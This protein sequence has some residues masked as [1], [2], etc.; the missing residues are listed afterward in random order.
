MNKCIN[1]FYEELDPDRWIPYDRYLRRLIRRLIR[2]KPRPGGQMRV[3]LNL[4]A[5]L[6]KLG[7]SYRINDYRYIQK[8]PEEIACI[9]GKHHV[10]DKIQWRNPILFGAAVFSHPYEDLNL[11][12]RLPVRK[13][14]VPGEWMRQMCQPYYE[15]RVVAWPVGIDTET[16]ISTSTVS[17]DVDILLYDKVLWEHN[18]YEENIVNRVHSYLNQQDLAIEV[19]RYGFY[20]EQDFKNLLKRCKAMVFLCEHETQGIAYQQALSSGVP[21]LAWDRGGYWQD[22]A[23]FPHRVKFAPVS[24][25]PYW[26]DRCGIKFTG[27]EEF[28]SKLEEFLDKLQQNQFAPREYILEN[29]TLEKCA[30]KYLDILNS[31]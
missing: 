7:V 20:Q 12:E 1:L 2:G 14:L 16:W 3:F 11:F 13:M 24:S 18:R 28:S 31:I 17:K 27:I 4:C 29:L 19:I 25:V 9:I 10:L 6:D 23:Y 30:Q 26:D 5:G 8:H 21:I 22:P 15:D